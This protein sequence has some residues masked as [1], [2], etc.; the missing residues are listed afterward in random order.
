MTSLTQLHH[1]ILAF[2]RYA[3]KTWQNPR[4]H[5]WQQLPPRAGS[6][7][8]HTY[9]HQLNRTRPVIIH[10]PDCHHHTCNCPPDNEAQP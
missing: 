4:H 3:A 2:R 5:R 6:R 1:R 7:L 9:D 10:C 8:I